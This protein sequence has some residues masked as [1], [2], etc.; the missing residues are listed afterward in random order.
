MEYRLQMSLKFI[1]TDTD[2]SAICDFLLVIHSNHRSVSY[3]VSKI[4]GDFDRKLK[5]NP[6]SR[7]LTPH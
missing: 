7:Y 1:V 6:T 2:R 3:T 4:N 5:K